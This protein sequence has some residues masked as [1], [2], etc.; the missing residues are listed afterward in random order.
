M[1]SK[2]DIYCQN[3]SVNRF[4][5][6]GL[7]LLLLLLLLLFTTII[8]VSIKSYSPVIDFLVS[9]LIS[10]IWSEGHTTFCSAQGLLLALY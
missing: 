7:L 9:Q 2:K 3:S 6:L 10:E 4:S 5:L 1:K 8:I